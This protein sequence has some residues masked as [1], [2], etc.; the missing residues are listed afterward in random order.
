MKRHKEQKQSS[1]SV[2]SSK[3]YV[4]HEQ[5]SFL[6]KIINTII[7]KALMIIKTKKINR[8]MLILR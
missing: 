2:K 8:T 5:M 4:L 6:N 3:L 1:S 7:M